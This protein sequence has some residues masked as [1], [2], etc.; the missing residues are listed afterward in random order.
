MGVIFEGFFKKYHDAGA[1]AA[2]R[3]LDARRHR[4]V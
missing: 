3:A 1:P 2:S 4:G